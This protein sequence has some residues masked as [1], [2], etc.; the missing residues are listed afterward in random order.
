MAHGAAPQAV[1]DAVCEETGKLMGA[2]TVNLAHFSPDHMNETVAGWS[3]HGVHLPAGTR[4]PLDGQTI[5]SLVQ[6]TEE[7]G[8]VDSYEGV[9]G[10]LADRLRALGIK[11]EVGAPVVI[12]GHVWGALI[13]GKDTFRPLPHGA[14]VRLAR[15]AE[16][17]ATAVSN[18]TTSAELVASRARIVTAAYDGRRRLA[19]DLHDGAQQRLVCTVMSLQLAD[20]QF[21]RDPAAARRLLL[22]ALGHARDGLG[23]LR[24]LAAG[25]H[26]G[27]L[28]NRGLHA[29]AEALARRSGLPVDLQVPDERFPP[30]IEAAAYFVTAEALTNVAK[31]AHA[32]CAH[33]CVGQHD[34]SLTV[35]VSDDGAGGADFRGSGLGGL[36]DRVEALGGGLWLDSPPGKGTRLHATLPL[37]SSY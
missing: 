32:S 18:A 36:K 30:H 26:P 33:V 17:I 37:S 31:H 11:N 3:V 21:E 25:V 20:Q 10:P 4:L 12:D 2:T 24:D 6:R 8:R 9:P 27:I 34:G 16:L 29:A 13:A 23:E 1:F 22:D 7:P 14:E 15:F 35:D 28:T 19:R 5:N